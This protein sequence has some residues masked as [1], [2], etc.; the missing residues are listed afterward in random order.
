MTSR[1]SKH[2]TPIPM[3]HLDRVLQS[4]RFTRTQNVDN[5]WEPTSEDQPIL[6]KPARKLK[7]GTLRSVHKTHQVKTEVAPERTIRCHRHGCQ[8]RLKLIPQSF[9]TQVWHQVRSCGGSRTR[10]YCRSSTETAFVMDKIKTQ[11]SRERFTAL[12]L[13]LNK[14]KHLP[15]GCCELEEK[16]GTLHI[17]DQANSTTHVRERQ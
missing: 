3:L 10:F 8:N 9:E 16:Q 4:P 7:T 13:L 2:S 6:E 12:Q 14:L 5:I 17:R 11:V 1:S 15:Q